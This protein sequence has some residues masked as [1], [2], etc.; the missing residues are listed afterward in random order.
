VFGS[1][2]DGYVLYASD[3]AGFTAKWDKFSKNGLRLISLESYVEN[4]KRLF[5]GAFRAGSGGYYSFTKAG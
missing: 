2:T 1:G 5:A 3:W 4:G